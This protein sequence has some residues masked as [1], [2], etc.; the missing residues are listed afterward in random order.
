MTFDH[1]S[2]KS[3]T[4]RLK[5]KPVLVGAHC[6]TAGG[7][8]KAI[9][10][11]AAI[12]CEC[13]QIFGS[14]PRQWKARVYADV[15]LRA[16]HQARRAHDVGPVFSHAIYLINLASA[17]A[18]IRQASVRA[19]A[20]GLRICHALRLDGLI[21]HVGSDGG[22]GFRRALPLIVGGLKRA[23]AESEPDS[24]VLLENSAG[25]RGSIGADVAELHA[26]IDATDHDPR[27][28]LCLD[29]AHAFAAGFDLREPDE[30]ERLI[31]DVRS[32]VGLE[33]L[34]ALHLNDSKTPVGSRRDRHENPGDGHLGLTG[35]TN[36]VT[37]PSVA[38]LPALLETPGFDGS[39]PDAHGVEIARAIA[40]S[41][42]YT[43]RGALRRAHTHVRRV[44][45]DRTSHSRSAA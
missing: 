13:L 15:E 32:S 45:A 31:D 30:V 11:A 18:R 20:A 42:K 16:W 33:R 21:V 25:A 43:A 6:S 3:S 10:R 44:R 41:G 38:G 22:R 34:A 1:A 5:A 35:L 23:F 40:G 24:R 27:L 12:G 17:S 4:R 37:H 28:G 19:L 14:N 7:A 26:I 29:S 39:G 9:E 2:P 36:L 8:H